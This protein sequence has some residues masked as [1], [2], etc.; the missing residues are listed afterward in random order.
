MN[1]E[2]MYKKELADAG[3]DVTDIKESEETTPEPEVKAEETKEIEAEPKVDESLTEPKEQHKRSIYEEYK[4]KKAELKSEREQREQVERERDELRAK[5][6]AVSQADTKEKREDAQDDLDSFAQ[7]IGADAQAIRRMRDLFLKDVKSSTDPVL[8]EKLEKF[9][10]WQKE[11]SVTLEKARFQEEF[12]AAT[13]TLKE[14]LP[15]VSDEEL[16]LVQEKVDELAHTKEYHDKDLDYVIF[17]NK[18]TLSKLVSPKK[19]GME[20]K[21]RKDVVE[22]SFDFDPNA[23][24]SKM[25]IKERE[26]WEEGYKKFT[27]GEGIVKDA[28]GRSVLI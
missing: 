12:T 14:L 3:V 8:A 13:P 15:N 4:D 21:S 10:A 23:D 6:E 11:N 19:R 24:Y 7:E 26:Q 25:S 9:E 18:E 22:E 2:E 17:K 27:S 28:R 16:K 5:L 20:S 1:E